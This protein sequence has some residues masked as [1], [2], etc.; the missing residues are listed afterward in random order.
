M[1]A[2]APHATRCDCF[3]R[4][5][6][7]R[8]GRYVRRGMG[9]AKKGPAGQID[10]HT[11]DQRHGA[12]IVSPAPVEVERRYRFALPDANVLFRRRSDLLAGRGDACG[13]VFLKSAVCASLEM[14]WS[15]LICLSLEGLRVEFVPG[16]ARRHRGQTLHR[17]CPCAIL[18]CAEIGRYT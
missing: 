1:P 4:L 16:L 11:L 8:C 7:L 13:G 17:S 5:R 2:V 14:G 9:A 15:P 12:V 6:R 10:R 3:W 18:A